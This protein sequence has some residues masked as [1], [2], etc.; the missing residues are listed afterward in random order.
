MSLRTTVSDSSQNSAVGIL[1]VIIS[2]P[3]TF[4]AGCDL[5]SSEHF[6]HNAGNIEKLG[7][8]LIPFAAQVPIAKGLF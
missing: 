2:G 6:T 5:P 3:P 4:T 7:L 8:S 1:I